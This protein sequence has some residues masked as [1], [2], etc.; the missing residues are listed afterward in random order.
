MNISTTTN[1]P[2]PSRSLGA[3]VASPSESIEILCT[4][5]LVGVSDRGLRP[6]HNQD[7]VALE[8]PQPDTA[9]MVV[10]DGISRSQTPELAAQNA[11]RITCRTL[12][13]LLEKGRSPKSALKAAINKAGEAVAELPYSSTV[14]LSPP[15][16]T[17]VAAVVKQGVATIGWLGDSRAYWIAP[18]NSCQLTEDD[19]WMHKMV[20]SGRMTAAEAMQSPKAHA[21]TR[22]LGA[23]RQQN[24][25]FSTLE[26]ELPPNAEMGHLLLCSDGLWHYTT[27]PRH[28][29]ALIYTSD[30]MQ[31]LTIAR[32][33]VEFARNRGGRDNITV[34]LLSIQR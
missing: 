22:W 31:P 11:A 30:C 6:N 17:I 29:E 33:L 1:S 4:K 26:F 15:S 24:A 23:D 25:H 32:N 10:C 19:S 21:I 18:G 14:A 2:H 28:L 8:S 13:R 34:A 16:T 3:S 20:G 12:S 5:Q 9:I 27:G 7:A